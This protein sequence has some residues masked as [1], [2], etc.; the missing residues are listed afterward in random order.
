MVAPWGAAF[1]IY[2]SQT[3]KMDWSVHRCICGKRVPTYKPGL[4]W[5]YSHVDQNQHLINLIF[6]TSL[7]NAGTTSAHHMITISD[8]ILSFYNSPLILFYHNIEQ[9]MFLCLTGW[10]GKCPRWLPSWSCRVRTGVVTLQNLFQNLSVQVALHVNA[11]CS[12][13][14]SSYLQLKVSICPLSTPARYACLTWN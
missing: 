2:R 11:L 3:L 1:N 4:D 9:K 12:I 13:S 5:Q 6:V 14:T 8:T 10:H 7:I